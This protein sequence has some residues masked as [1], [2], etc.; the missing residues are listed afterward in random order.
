MSGFRF[1]FEHLSPAGPGARLSIL[2]F[3]RVLENDDPLLPSEPDRR[4]FE[5]QMLW[6]R[7][8]FN[9]LPLGEAVRRLG[10]R[11]LPARSLAIT[12]DDGYANNYNV[13]LPVLTRL[14]LPATFFV[15]S[16]YLDGGRMFN[17]TV[18]E[19]VRRCRDEVLDLGELQLGRHPLRAVAE[20]RAAVDR[21]LPALIHLPADER[22]SKVAAIA[23]RCGSSLPR[24]L[25]MTSDQVAKLH[26]AGM[27][28][29]AHTSSH[30]ILPTLNSEAATREIVLGRSRLEEITGA[31]VELFAYP[32]G[33]P[34]QDYDRTHVQMVRDLG[35]EGAVSTAIGFATAGSDLF[36]LP[37]F[38]PWDR[39]SLKY[40]LRL[41]ENLRRSAASIV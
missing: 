40:G 1:L 10:A 25:M 2:I 8:W 5:A 6:V 41:A 35:F 11:T 9:V 16:G 26:A 17:D 22:E 34:G 18:I 14:G 36:Q 15:A 20:R 12:F 29:G 23:E 27:S 19:A 28:V 32:N 24:D 7:R 30:P 21:L 33:K 4:R 37:R 13:A 3:H 31:P 38:T 39:S